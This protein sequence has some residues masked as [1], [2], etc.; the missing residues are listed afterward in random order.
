[1]RDKVYFRTT[2]GSTQELEYDAQGNIKYHWRS[3]R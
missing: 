3:G 2:G 1:M